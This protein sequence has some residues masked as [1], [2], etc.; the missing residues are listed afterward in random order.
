[1]SLVVTYDNSGILAGTVRALTVSTTGNIG[2]GY[3]N[4]PAYALD[5]SGQINATST[6]STPTLVATSNMYTNALYTNGGVNA[7]LFQNAGT[8][9]IGGSYTSATNVGINK[10]NPA[11]TLD[12]SG[13][14]RS[15]SVIN[16]QYFIW[17]FNWN[18]T[19]S[20]GS[21]A[22]GTGIC[23]STGGT[24]TATTN[25]PGTYINTPTSGRLTVPVSGVYG[26]YLN[27]SSDSGADGAW[28]QLR[29]NGANYNPNRPAVGAY[30]Q[31]NSVEF[32][33]ANANDILDFYVGWDTTNAAG[34]QSTRGIN[35]NIG[36][37][38]GVTFTLM[39]RTA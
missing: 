11:Y 2:I 18:A 14:F 25:I 24:T 1:M 9:T 33:Y 8:I 37:G 17:H 38:Q 34:L 29:I 31:V 39:Q 28:P 3:N 27:A 6:I 4:N 30:A 19:Q 16:S 15:V 22:G 35:A 7:F 23:N 26:C 5:V 13:V 21:V 32:V 10:T 20:R 36:S 12:V